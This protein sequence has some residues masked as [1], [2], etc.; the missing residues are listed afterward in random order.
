[1]GLQLADKNKHHTR[2]NSNLLFNKELLAQ[3][4]RGLDAYLAEK[5]T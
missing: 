3:A 2:L 1:M 4:D 5:T